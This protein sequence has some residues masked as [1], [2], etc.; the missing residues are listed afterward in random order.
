MP[1]LMLILRTIEEVSSIPVTRLDESNR[2]KEAAEALI[3]ELE[4]Y[5]GDTNLAKIQRARIK[6]DLLIP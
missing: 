4:M 1:R 6:S 2:V 5:L 3:E